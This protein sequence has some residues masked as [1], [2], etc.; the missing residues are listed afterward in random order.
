VIATAPAI[1]YGATQFLATGEPGHGEAAPGDHLQTAYHFWLV[2]D[3]LEHGRVPWR[4]PYSFR[5]E[6]HWT[7]NPAAWPYGLL[8][9]PLWRALGLVLAWNVFV[10]LSFVGAGALTCAW[11]RE[12]RLPRGAA[13]AGGLAFAL[14]P[15]RVAQSTGHLLGPISILLPLA[16]FA[17]ERGLRGSRWWLVLSVAAIASIPL[18][19]QVHLALGAV[20]FY[21]AY[22]LGRSRSR[23]SF[24]AVGTAVVLAAAAGALI[25]YEV[26]RGSIAAGG[27]PLSAVDPYSADW[28]D[29]LVR[30]ERHG[31]EQF[32]FVGWLVPLAAVLGLVLLW[33]RGERWLSVLFGVG[34]LVPMVLA[35]GTNTP[36]Y[37]LARF[38]FPPLRYPRVPE[39]LMPVACLC[40]AALVA[41]VVAEAEQ[42]GAARAT[43]AL[44]RLGSRVATVPGATAVVALC[45]VLLVLD[46][47]V[48][49]FGASRADGANRAYSALR[50]APPGRVAEVPYFRPGSDRGSAY[51]YYET[52][53]RRPRPGGYSTTAPAA[54]DRVAKALL[55]LNCGD[56]TAGRARILG[57]LGVTSIAFHRGLFKA[58]G[59]RSDTAWFAWRGLIRHG[60]KRIARDGAVTM[61]ARRG[62][63]PP[64]PAREPPHGEL[65][66][67]DGWYESEGRGRQMSLDHAGFWIHDS[68]DLRLF[69][70]ADRPLPLTISVDGKPVVHRV[71]SRL[72]E[73]RAPLGGTGWHLVALDA[74]ISRSH[75][76]RAGARLVGW[77]RS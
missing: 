30:H 8:F 21:A 36:L 4:D 31:L 7:L 54:T 64:V 26:I 41:Y 59:G 61:L 44:R 49:V 18:S 51:L 19:G 10:L 60:W 9:W 56:W 65:L 50:A 68:G 70:E 58:G 29:F 16:L 77:A 1:R 75:G 71:V 32:V 39:R 42:R 57:H 34:A 28:L 47:R 72:A 55:P 37:R 17:L 45:L 40:L 63:V 69:L 43:Q 2:G 20:P 62:W 38:A 14:A 6:A 5:P 66:Y 13:L 73:V 22:A 27:R 53:S 76:R 15:Y 35:L 12:L 48:N 11:L 25:R 3:N 24:A 46:L 74:A 52:Q 23:W 67:C 33:Q